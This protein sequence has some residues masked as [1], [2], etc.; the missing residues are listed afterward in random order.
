MVLLCKKKKDSFTN[1][2]TQ[3]GMMMIMFDDRFEVPQHQ[4]NMYIKRDSQFRRNKIIIK[5]KI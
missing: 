3:K 5:W 4:H 1:E 2:T